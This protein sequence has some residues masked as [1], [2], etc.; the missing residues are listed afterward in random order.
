[1]RHSETGKMLF[2]VVAIAVVAVVL[3]MSPVAV[4]QS[5]GDIAR[6]NREKQNAEDASSAAAKPK[7][8]TNKDLPKDPNADVTP[9]AVPAASVTASAPTGAAS[10]SKTAENR[11]AERHFAQQRAGEQR[12]AEQWKRQIVAQKTR[13]ANLEARIDQVQASIRVA[14]GEV[15][16][17]QPFNHYQA[18]QLQQVALMQQQLN[19]QRIRLDQ[20]QDAAR[21]AGM[22]TAVYDP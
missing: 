14:N 21:R 11:A 7:V 3:L 19:E 12:A 2:D 20:M 6:E 15:Q 16:A 10:S 13:I 8:I 22:H 9:N 1:M 4:G 5:L 18:R 17:E